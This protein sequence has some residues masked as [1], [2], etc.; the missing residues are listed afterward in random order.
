MFRVKIWY[1]SACY[2]N[3]LLSKCLVCSNVFV[4]KKS[5]KAPLKK[6]WYGNFLSIVL[7]ICWWKRYVYLLSENCCVCIN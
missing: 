5:S 4:T 2:L 7:I 3:V 1:M 6:K